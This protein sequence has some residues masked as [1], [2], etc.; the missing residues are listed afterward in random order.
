MSNS[1]APVEFPDA[2]VK[3]TTPSAL[4]VEVDG[5][6]VWV[7]RSQLLEENDVS[8]EGEEGLLVIPEWLAIE[9]GL[10]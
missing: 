5:R 10:V 6:K 9:R 7:P 2:K 1:R 8:E 4:L 3:R